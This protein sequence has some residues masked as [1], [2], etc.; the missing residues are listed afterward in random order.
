M[1]SLLVAEHQHEQDSQGESDQGQ[2]AFKAHIGH[3][4][5]SAD[6]QRSSIDRGSDHAQQSA[7]GNDGTS[8]HGIN[9]HESQYRSH[10]G[11]SRQNSS[12]RRTSDHAGEHDDEHDEDQKNSGETMEFLDNQA[13]QSIQRTGFFDNFHKDHGAADGQNGIHITELA[14]HHHT[15]GFSAEAAL[16]SSAERCYQHGNADRQLESKAADHEDTD[17]HNKSDHIRCHNDV[18]L[19]LFTAARPAG[20]CGCY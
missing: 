2:R 6:D 3:I 5:T 15:D 14:F 18:L 9:A 13:A 20:R 7:H 1:A 8:G 12:S 17:H 16:Q 19:I 10:N 11:T 4:D